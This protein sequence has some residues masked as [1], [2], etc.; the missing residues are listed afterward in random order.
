M[1]TEE[2]WV[3][4]LAHLACIMYNSHKLQTELPLKKLFK[5]YIACVHVLFNVLIIR[6]DVATGEYKYAIRPDGY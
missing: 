3:Y 1:I 5:D 2:I 4:N 6:Y